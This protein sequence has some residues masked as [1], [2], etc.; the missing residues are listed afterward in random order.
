VPGVCF[1]GRA[2]PPKSQLTIFFSSKKTTPSP[3]IFAT[4]CGK[5]SSVITLL[6]PIMLLA[7]RKLKQCTPQWKHSHA[8]VPAR[9]CK[10]CSKT[11][12]PVH[13]ELCLGP[14]CACIVSP[15]WIV[16]WSTVHSCTVKSPHI[17]EFY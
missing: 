2:A 3:T 9:Q 5:S 17:L 16:S 7:K 14:Q 8:T 15:Q 4:L 10:I 12:M 6:Q 13:S 11:I 1:Q